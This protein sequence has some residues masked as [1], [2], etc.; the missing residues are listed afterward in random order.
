VILPYETRW[1]TSLDGLQVEMVATPRGPIE[2]AHAGEGPAVLL[3][4]GIPGSW[5]QAIPLAEDLAGDFKVVLVSRPGYG[6][7]PLSTGR[8]ATQQADAF[9]GVLEALGIDR[10]AVVGISGGG[11][12]GAAFAER[13][14]SRTS[15]LVLACALTA[16]LTHIP[17]QMRVLMSIP[18][19]GEITSILTRRIAR[20]RL[21]DPRAVERASRKNL[22]ADEQRRMD[23]DP[24]IRADLLR[25]LLSHL[26]A[27]AALGGFRNDLAQINRTRGGGH[28]AFAG[29]ACP[30]LIIHGDSDETV[31]MDHARFYAATIPHAELVVYENAGH[32][33]LFTRRVEATARIAGFLNIHAG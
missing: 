1:N 20:L 24:Q 27:P 10:S 15:A 18:L 8:T 12:P 29:A 4:H 30:T 16:H 33:F 17:N 6:A 3:V 13:H 2:V 19:L 25:F 5:R 23:E 9:A 28:P 7:T 26:D 32:L 21:K 11:P 22:T 14:P 31:S